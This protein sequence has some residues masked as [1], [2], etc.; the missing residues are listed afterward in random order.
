MGPLPMVGDYMDTQVPTLLPEMEILDA[1]E[2]L[3]GHHVTGA[4]VVDAY[5]RLIGMLT[6]RDCLK[7]LSVGAEAGM[8]R[9]AV[10]DFMTTDLI[11]VGPST[12]VYYAAGLF[13][14]HT[15]RRLPVVEKGRLAGAITRFDI[16]RVI[17]SNL[18]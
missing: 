15:F 14:K 7:L 2:Y 13:L 18:R 8:P 4:P 11:T 6:E 16:L 9:G 5:G 17:R 12:D 3:L 1:V 10:Q